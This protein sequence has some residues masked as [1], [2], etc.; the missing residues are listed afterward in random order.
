MYHK[1]L[2]LQIGSVFN[3][4]DQHHVCMLLEYGT[5]FMTKTQCIML[6][7]LVTSAVQLLNVC[8]TISNCHSEQIISD[9][10]KPVF[11]YGDDCLV[12]LHNIDLHLLARCT[13]SNN[14][15]RIHILTTT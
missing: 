6:L 12:N 8:Q 3:K 14:F 9:K 5:P 4:E 11:S 2:Y 10:V 7:E 13:Q 15:N 1:Q